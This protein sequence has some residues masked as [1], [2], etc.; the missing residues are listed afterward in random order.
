MTDRESER[1]PALQRRENLQLQL[2]PPLES[3][4]WEMMRMEEA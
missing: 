1:V 4:K 3:L 2:L